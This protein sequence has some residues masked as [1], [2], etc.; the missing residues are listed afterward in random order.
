MEDEDLIKMNL[1]DAVIDFGDEDDDQDSDFEDH[2]EIKEESK[3]EIDLV[4]DDEINET[5]R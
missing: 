4:D 2:F 3:D 1:D 5:V